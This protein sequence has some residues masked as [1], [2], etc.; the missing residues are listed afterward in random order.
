MSRPRNLTKDHVA[1]AAAKAKGKRKKSK[2]GTI[3]EMLDHLYASD[4]L[5]AAQCTAI[6]QCADTAA[7]PGEFYQI[8]MLQASLAT[9]L[10]ARKEMDPEAYLKV[11]RFVGSQMHH[12]LNDQKEEVN[13]T[14]VQ[15][16]ADMPQQAIAM[17]GTGG[18]PIE[19][20]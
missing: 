4:Q 9:S 14:S 15:I 19:V 2:G 6:E 16:N 10:F 11:M 8:V 7:T 3:S 20:H 1:D 13:I 5:T 17:F 12:L 18:D